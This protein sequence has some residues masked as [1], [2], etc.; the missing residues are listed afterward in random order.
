MLLLSTVMVAAG[1]GLTVRRPS[2]RTVP[3]VDK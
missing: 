2:P 3:V 1:I